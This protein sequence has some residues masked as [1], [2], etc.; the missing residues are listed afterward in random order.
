MVLASSLKRLEE[1]NMNESHD[2]N[3]F[4]PHYKFDMNL[5]MDEL[6]NMIVSTTTLKTL[7][8]D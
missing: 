6:N 8:L 3:R 7:R 1:I 2:Y 4:Y 5:T